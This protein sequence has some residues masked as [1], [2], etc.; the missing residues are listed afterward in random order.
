MNVEADDPQGALD[1][2]ER[3]LTS[4]GFNITDEGSDVFE[5]DPGAEPDGLWS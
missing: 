2:L 4:A 5:A 1:V 3:A